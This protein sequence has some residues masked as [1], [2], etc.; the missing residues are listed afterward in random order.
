MSAAILE[1]VESIAGPSV[2]VDL[3]QLAANHA[4]VRAQFRG[5]KLG[6]VVKTDAYGLGLGPVAARL[7]QEGC[8]DF[9]VGDH[10]EG[11]RLRRM[12]PAAR[13]FVLDGLTGLSPASFAAA[14]LVPVLASLD[15]VRRCRADPA[16][17]PVAIHLDCGLTRL[18][19]LDAEVVALTAE[20]G[21]LAG[22][23]IEA[24]VTQLSHYF[25]PAH[26]A[27]QRQN[28][29]FLALAGYF[30]RVPLSLSSSAGVF[31]PPQ[32]HHDLARVGS[33]LYGVQTTPGLPQPVR[34][35]FRFTAPVLRV[36]EVEAG[37][38][39]G[40]GGG[41]VASRRARIATIG[42][43]YGNGLPTTL[44]SRGMV[45]IGGHA[46]P[47]AGRLSMNLITVDVTDLPSGLV[48]PG[49]EAELAG[50]VIP[51]EELATRAGAVPNEILV[52]AGRT[53]PRR[54]IGR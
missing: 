25:A 24:L 14:R 21:G 5:Q 15:E 32:F 54:Y 28:A 13:I 11:V 52:R 22:L 43:G 39:I 48:R 29:R 36:V 46:A 18:G 3:D 33:A 16:A 2:T 23:R 47:I 12:L 27:N 10:A 6:A 38:P 26:P 45:A 4:A 20:P 53:M 51:I 41:F 34:P 1:D 35:I 8:S 7:W 19:L 42:A 31:M 30:G 50:P 9:W 17:P 49:V 40:Y 37:T 44:A